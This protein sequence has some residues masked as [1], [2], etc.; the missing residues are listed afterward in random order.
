MLWALW[1]DYPTPAALAAADPVVLEGLL[2]PLGLHRKRALMI[3][4]FSAEYMDKQ[5]R[6]D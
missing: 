2:R 6:A 3:K 4:R 5:V 1:R